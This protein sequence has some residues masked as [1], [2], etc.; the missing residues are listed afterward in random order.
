MLVKI[1]VNEVDIA[2]LKPGQLTEVTIDAER[3]I[4]FIGRVHKVAPASQSSDTSGTSSTSSSGSSSTAV[5]RFPV[6]IQIDHA[7]RRLKPGMSA[8]CSVIVARRRSVLRLPT[9]C[10]TGD[11][12]SGTVQIVTTVEKDG[13][14][15]E[16]TTP[17]E[18]QIGLRGDSFVEI[19]SGV[20][21]GEK[22]RPNP[23][24]GPPRKNH[25]ARPNDN[26][27]NNRNN[28]GT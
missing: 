5:V 23:F 13:Q 20:K 19:V 7:D 1:N 25:P 21:E 17:R 12:A 24:N 8:R 26:D 2:K 3:G 6:E 9:N 11:G 28:N 18:V 10:V 4:Q 22:V 15:V 14:K 16:Q 27:R